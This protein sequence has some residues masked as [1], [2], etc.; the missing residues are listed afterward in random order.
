MSWMSKPEIRSRI[1]NSDDLD[2]GCSTL[3]RAKI[4]LLFVGVNVVDD[5]G[6]IIAQMFV[7]I[8]C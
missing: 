3:V 1:K 4:S 5:A 2:L 7:G 6:V 8:R